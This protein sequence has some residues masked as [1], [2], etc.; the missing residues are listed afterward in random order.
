[1]LVPGSLA[2]CSVMALL[3]LTGSSASAEPATTIRIIV[4]NALGGGIDSAARLLS[5]QIG[6][7]YHATVIVENRPGAGGVIGTEDVARS[8][9]DGNTLLFDAGNLIVNAQVRAVHYNPLTSFE[10][11]CDLISAPNLIVVNGSSPFGTLANLIS[12]A[13]AKPGELTLASSGPATALQIEFEKFKRAADVNIT[14]VPYRGTAPAVEAVLGGHVTSAIASYSVVAEQLK[15]GTLRA[16]AAGTRIETLPDVPSLAESGYGSAAYEGWEG[17]FAPAGTPRRV[18][19]L[20]SPIGSQRQ[21]RP[22]R[23][24]PD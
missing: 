2:A 13:R 12:A 15:A 8:A 3:A 10:P 21:C 16:L 18:K 19:S 23:S 5:R 1:M 11:I 20:S 24:S 9:P 22:P 4:P 17:L 14:F 6:Q 7:A